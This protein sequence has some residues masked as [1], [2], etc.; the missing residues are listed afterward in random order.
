MVSVSLVLFRS[1]AP[2]DEW[3]LVVA[4]ELP[5]RGRWIPVN[6]WSGIVGIRT[7]VVIRSVIV[8]TRT[9]TDQKHTSGAYGYQ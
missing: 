7:D 9:T 3:F 1:A 8:G 6:L 2:W 5:V 4:G